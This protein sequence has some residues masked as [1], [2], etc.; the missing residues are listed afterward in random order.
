MNARAELTPPEPAAQAQNRYHIVVAGEFNA[1]KSSLINL[2]LRQRLLPVAVGPSHLPPACIVPAP[3]EAFTIRTAGGGM[4]VDKRDFLSG[5]A[6]N[7][8]IARIE[9]EALAPDF[10]GA[11]ISEVSVGQNGDL[12]AEGRA[13]LESADLLIWCTMGQRAWCLSEINIVEQLPVSLRKNAVLAVT[14][15][16]Y[17]H[18]P[19]DRGKV[20]SRLAGEVDGLFEKIIM[21]DCSR[22]AI[23]DAIISPDRHSTGASA[24]FKHVMAEFQRSGVFAPPEPVIERPAPVV[25]KPQPLPSRQLGQIWRQE[26]DEIAFWIETRPNISGQETAVHIRDRIQR[27]VCETRSEAPQASPSAATA[28]KQAAALLDKLQ[29]RPEAEL[30]ILSVD[31]AIQLEACFE[32]HPEVRM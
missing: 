32:K 13:V 1:G 21:L 10:Q 20:S 8:D 2:L 11:Q 30:A 15:A 18:G 5:R 4:H 14:R 31:L 26:V 19:E 17:L 12:P 6:E 3:H 16:D 27:F 25:A 28:F 22:K 7:I 24:L 23:D 9:I 29:N